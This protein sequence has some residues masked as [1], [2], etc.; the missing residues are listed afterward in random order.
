VATPSPLAPTWG[1]TFGKLGL[2]CAVMF[3][4]SLIAFIPG[5]LVVATFL[6][7][8]PGLILACAPEMFLVS[9]TVLVGRLL[10][11]RSDGAGRLAVACALIAAYLL[12]SAGAAAFFNHPIQTQIQELSRDDHDL[13][14][15]L[16][17]AR[18]I[19]IRVVT[20][21]GLDR[22]S[23][24][25]SRKP[26]HHRRPESD[27]GRDRTPK[28]DCGGL[29]LHL[30]FNGLADSV[31]VTS[32]SR[33]VAD[34]TPSL[35][36]S[37]TQFRLERRDVC[38][39]VSIHLRDFFSSANDPLIQYGDEASERNVMGQIA[40]GRCLIA[41][42][43]SLS[44]A[45]IIV[46]VNQYLLPPSPTPP[47]SMAMKVLQ[48]DRLSLEARRISIYQVHEDRAEERFRQTTIY[49]EPLLPV[50]LLGPVS[51]GEGGIGISEGFLRSRKVY[52]AWRMHDIFKTK[53]GLDMSPISE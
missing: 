32:V 15:T 26:K 5:I 22:I 23:R 38:P 45:D 17:G 12:A 8:V 20:A 4:L 42:A 47:T 29:C 11:P 37:A 49:A 41:E 40:R 27:T 51:T 48:L 1:K 30:L 39:D 3:V 13:R 14:G 24:P 19:A 31:L 2:F 25:I 9:A 50:L 52:S 6:L 36:E 21:N 44:V 28:N 18:H 16:D 53:L 34:P 43:A 10:F 46:Q 7:I 35:T 33:L